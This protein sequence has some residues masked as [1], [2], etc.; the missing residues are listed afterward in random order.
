MNPPEMIGSFM[1]DVSHDPPTPAPNSAPRQTRAAESHPGELETPDTVASSPDSF[2]P[3]L[4]AVADCRAKPDGDFQRIVVV[5]APADRAR[6]RLGGA[7]AR[8]CCAILVTAASIRQRHLLEPLVRLCL[9]GGRPVLA[10]DEAEYLGREELEILK[11]LINLTPA[12]L[13]LLSTAPA[14]RTWS[15]RWPIEA[16]QLR[17]RTHLVLERR[18]LRELLDQFIS[19]S[20]NR[21]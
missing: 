1:K 18:P 21:E 15:Q 2:Q 16:R 13:V 11:V 17:R 9:E 6:A 7:L 10:V 4:R 12:V 3:V 8:R 5:L 19:Q 14:Y 20:M